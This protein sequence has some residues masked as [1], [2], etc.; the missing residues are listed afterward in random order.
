MI[1]QGLRLAAKFGLGIWEISWS[2]GE[3]DGVWLVVRSEIWGVRFCCHVWPQE[4]GH[5]V[6]SIDDEMVNFWT[7]FCFEKL[8]LCLIPIYCVNWRRTL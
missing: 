6:V 4:A 3:C 5:F 1:S 7:E 2:I 8:L